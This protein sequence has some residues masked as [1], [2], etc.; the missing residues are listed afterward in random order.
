MVDVQTVSIAVASAGVFAAAIYYIFQIRHQTKLRQMDLVMRLYS[1]YNSR[2]FVEAG[3][4][5]LAADFKNCNEFVAKYGS[6]PSETPVQ[7]AFAIVTSFFEEVGE[8]LHK[9]LIDIELIE[10]MFAV[11]MYWEKTEP[12]IMDLRKQFTLK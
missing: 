4:R 1:T 9:K 7:I 10:E 12:V 11:K 2:E 6:I 3:I 5:L 8:L